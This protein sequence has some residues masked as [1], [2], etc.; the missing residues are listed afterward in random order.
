MIDGVKA[1]RYPESH[2]EK[3]SEAPILLKPFDMQSKR[4][5]LAALEK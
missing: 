5:A 1:D 4:R 2:F 3:I